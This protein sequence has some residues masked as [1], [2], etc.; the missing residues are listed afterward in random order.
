LRLK[1]Q[2]FQRLIWRERGGG[3]GGEGNEGD[4]EKSKEGT[5]Y[6]PGRAARVRRGVR[7]YR[8]FFT[9]FLIPFVA[10]SA[11]H[12]PP[13][14]SPDEALKPLGLKSQTAPL[15][16]SP[17]DTEIIC[18]SDD[19]DDEPPPSKQQ[20]GHSFLC[21]PMNQ[22]TSHATARSHATDRRQQQQASAALVAK[23][24]VEKPSKTC[25]F[26]C[27]T[28]IS[29]Y[30]SGR[31]TKMTGNGAMLEVSLSF[32]SSPPCGWVLFHSPPNRT[33]INK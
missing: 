31:K 19:S 23:Y 32:S 29:V 4:K 30:P 20:Q 12:T 6:T 13:P 2:G 33:H 1:A 22:A 7:I 21:A 18:I 8:S 14:L 15:P 16:S 17:P 3:G 26:A 5:I 28:T 25:T 10:L 9:Y 11:T 24:Q 27:G